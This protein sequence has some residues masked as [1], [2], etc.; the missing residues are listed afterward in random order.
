[1]CLACAHVEHM[2]RLGQPTRGKPRYKEAAAVLGRDREPCPRQWERPHERLRPSVDCNL[3]GIV[4]Q[5]QCDCKVSGRFC[6]LSDV[7]LCQLRS[8]TL[9]GSDSASLFPK[10]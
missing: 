10:R 7:E 1:M 2:S 6:V 4:V 3:R 5:D 9:C 8:V